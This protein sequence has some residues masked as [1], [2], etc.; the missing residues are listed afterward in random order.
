MKLLTLFALLASAAA[1]T[2]SPAAKPPTSLSSSRRTFVSSG[3]A[4]LT[5][6]AAAAPALAI[7]D[8]EGLGYLGGGT[9]V[10]VNNANVRAYLKMPGMYPTVAGKVVSNGP[11]SSVGDVFNIPGLSSRE[12]EVR[13]RR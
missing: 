11:Y 12:K 7:R 5:A 3:A 4:F 10:D 13:E 2:T 8:Y 9:Q 1:F 6:A